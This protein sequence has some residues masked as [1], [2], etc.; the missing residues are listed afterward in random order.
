MDVSRRKGSQ[1]RLYT[2][3]QPQAGRLYGLCA[4][5]C[6]SCSLVTQLRREA[7]V[8][9]RLL[10]GV[11]VATHARSS[12]FSL[13]RRRGVSH[14]SVLVA[15]A[16]VLATGSPCPGQVA[17]VWSARYG[18]VVDGPDQP[19]GVAFDDDGNVFVTCSSGGRY[20]TIKYDRDGRELW[21]AYVPALW[22][23]YGPS[24][25][26]VDRAG[27]VTI[28]SSSGDPY[29]VVQYDSNGRELWATRVRHEGITSVVKLAVD[30]AGNT[31]IAG[32]PFVTIKYDPDGVKLW[33][34]RWRDR[35]RSDGA[36]HDIGLD[37][38]GN[39]YVAGFAPTGATL[40]KYN[41]EGVLLWETQSPQLIG[42]PFI[43][44][45]AVDSEGHAHVALGQRGLAEEYVTQKH[46]PSGEK[47]WEARYSGIDGSRSDAAAIALD[48]AGNVFVAGT[49]ARKA[50][51]TGLD[52]A[53]VKYDAK[54]RELW[55]QRFTRPT[56]QY[57]WVSS[58]TTDLAGNAFV[59]GTTTPGFKAT[60]L[61]YGPDGTLLW[62][63]N[64]D[65]EDQR[66][67]G[68]DGQ[69][70]SV[71][72]VR[73]QNDVVTVKRDPDG[74]ALWEQRHN[75]R[76][77]G[78]DAATAVGVD[79]DGNVYVAGNSG[80][81]FATLK[82][83]PDGKE[84][85]SARSDEPPIGSAT[86]AILRLDSA[87]NV[88]VSGIGLEVATVKYDPQ[89]SLLWDIRHSRPGWTLFDNSDLAVD[90]AGNAYVLESFQFDCGFEGCA[91]G[92]FTA[93]K[94]S[95]EGEELW[96][97]TFDT[98]DQ[99]MDSG[100]AIA[101]GPTG[102]VHVAGHRRPCQ[103]GAIGVGCADSEFIVL[104]YDTDGTLLWTVQKG[105]TPDASLFAGNVALGPGGSVYVTG[106]ANE[107]IFVLSL[108]A[109]GDEHW[110]ARSTFDGGSGWPTSVA[111]DASG[112]V[113]VL[114][115]VFDRL[116]NSKCALVKYSSGGR[117]L[118]RAVLESSYAGDF[119]HR[120]PQ[121]ALDPQ[122][123]IYV[124]TH[125]G[126]E[127]ATLKYDPTGSLAWSAIRRDEIFGGGGATAIALD[128]KGNVHVT[129]TG[130]GDFLTVKYAQPLPQR[131]VRGDCDGDGRTVGV[132]DAVFLLAYSFHGA[133]LP[134]CLSACDANGDG[135]LSGVTDAVALLAYHFLG[136]P[137]PPPPF[138]GCGLL[139]PSDARSGC[140]VAPVV[141]R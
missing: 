103:H 21:I 84:I 95:P 135:S 3:A 97:R 110:E 101:V 31:F 15:S 8:Y 37:L 129:G 96:A 68:L 1:F 51:D 80:R 60:T 69:G 114:G 40:V 73:E 33:A 134:Q 24:S 124:A 16:F 11:P 67:I 18:S 136:G 93:V 10:L 120:S 48:T 46:S 63:A 13:C 117:E 88:I 71:I 109:D 74:N 130:G 64:D 7:S 2:Q 113:V 50:G 26:A 52:I 122:G 25:L 140:A 104:T 81:F 133:T 94:I 106:T 55:V 116:S 91:D 100:R 132:T 22:S 47:L 78:A 12:Q 17:E 23:Y 126:L 118:W 54:G 36:V 111:V 107:A 82:Y 28:G 45:L 127:F 53:T 49:S 123:G 139:E 131:F 41:P 125:I 115:L 128:A 44:A 90:A 19:S 62:S 35:T 58:L 20:A 141:C 29:L 14:T 61:K 43:R 77:S 108:G 121:V 70:N 119:P 86:P 9:D 42:A 59:F 27:R 83:G 76:I 89:G 34:T 112:E 92:A 65:S 30:R 105:G 5:V 38:A 57:A 4:I 39:V 6:P 99:V 137:P 85:W 72:A 98:P 66:F 32:E 79:G 56:Q 87:G 138:P 75:S 102:S